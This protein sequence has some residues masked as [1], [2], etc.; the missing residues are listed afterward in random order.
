MATDWVPALADALSQALDEG[1]HPPR[2]RRGAPERFTVVNRALETAV[3]VPT[4]PSAPRD[5]LLTFATPLVQDRQG[6]PLLEPG[7]VHR[8]AGPAGYLI[9]ARECGLCAFRV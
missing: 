8:E 9:A 4:P 3:T 7:A 1:I 5:A 6:A 2:S